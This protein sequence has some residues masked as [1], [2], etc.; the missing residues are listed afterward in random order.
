MTAYKATPCFR[1]HLYKSHFV[2]AYFDEFR[3]DAIDEAEHLLLQPYFSISFIHL[4]LIAERHHYV[5]YNYYR[6]VT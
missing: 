5:I 1:Y 3:R 2:T 6:T 4:H